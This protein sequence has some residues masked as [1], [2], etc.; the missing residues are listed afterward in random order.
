MRSSLTMSTALSL[1][2]SC[3]AVYAQPGNP[4][5]PPASAPQ[6][7]EPL[8]FY[9]DLAQSIRT[10]EGNAKAKLKGGWFKTSVENL[11]IIW[12]ISPNTRATLSFKYEAR[13]LRHAKVAFDPPVSAQ[14]A[15]TP[16]LQV[17][18]YK[19]EYDEDGALTNS[20]I[21][22]V[23]PNSPAPDLSGI[24]A[25][26]NHLRFEDESKALFLGRP[27]KKWAAATQIDANGNPVGQGPDQIVEE[28]T[29]R[30]EGEGAPGLLVALKEGATL[31][32]SPKNWLRVGSPCTVQFDK[33]RYATNGRSLEGSL[34]KL[35]CQLIDA[36]LNSDRADL[37]VA[38][39]SQ[40]AFTSI[41][42]HLENGS[43]TVGGG[44]AEPGISFQRFGDGTLKGA[45]QV[46][47]PWY[48]LQVRLTLRA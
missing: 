23:N 17:L 20:E 37:L 3:T 13:Y 35:D 6:P 7:P 21:K 40:I 2:F 38:S 9:W 41:D 11:D 34:S 46:G 47:R 36:H 43:G 48:C 8:R 15:G 27:W 19:L 32:I 22:P 16:T 39:G 10:A 5:T 44:Q 25:I 33:I 30:N 18:I 29:F 42:F 12:G 31:N 1:V 24:T 4:A 26:G 28:I 45:F 14:L